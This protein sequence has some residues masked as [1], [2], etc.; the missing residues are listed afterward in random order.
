MQGL[1]SEQMAKRELRK[2][3]TRGNEV[4]DNLHA[5]RLETQF[6]ACANTHGG[7]TGL[8]V[9]GVF[10][11]CK[12]LGKKL[13]RTDLMKVFREMDR[14]ASGIVDL[15]EFRQWWEHEHKR[16]LAK[17]KQTEAEMALLAN[18]YT[19]AEEAFKFALVSAED[20]EDEDK[21]VELLQQ[22]LEKTKACRHNL[23]SAMDALSLAHEPELASSTAA[24]VRS[25]SHGHTTTSRFPAF[26]QIQAEL[27]GHL[28]KQHRL[29]AGNQRTIRTATALFRY[30][31]AE[32]H[33]DD[34]RFYKGDTIEILLEAVPEMGPGWC[35]GRVRAAI[36]YFPANVVEFSQAQ[37]QPEPEPQS[38]ARREK[39]LYGLA[40]RMGLRVR[41]GGRQVFEQAFMK[42]D[43]NRNGLMD[44]DEFK[45]YLQA[46]GEWETDPVATDEHWEESWPRLCQLLG[47]PDHEAGI[48]LERC[49]SYGCV[50]R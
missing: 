48:S 30:Q 3:Q 1:A 8:N 38:N 2:A 12:A 36:G 47:E 24:F 39:V 34:L 9:D 31:P 14:D 22:G 44:K 6:R 10:D 32:E 11:L 18:Q 4:A 5:D 26:N 27:E 46:V 49:V 13:K 50:Y 37:R 16:D 29:I 43:V 21:L 45:A 7:L 28:V 41:V 20:A 35:L 17:A 33:G 19:V 42:H 40:V 23:S 25:V 15:P